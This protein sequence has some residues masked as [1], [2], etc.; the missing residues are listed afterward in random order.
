MTCLNALWIAIDIEINA[1]QTIFQADAS[2]ITVEALFLVY[3][4]SEL[5]VRFCAQR[6]LKACMKDRWFLFDMV[7]VMLLLLETWL[8]PAIVLL[9][10]GNGSD[11]GLATATTMLRILRLL[12][13]LRTARIARIV[14][15][16]PELL[17]LIKGLLVASKSVFFA[18]VLFLLVTY[19]FSIALL[20]LSEETELQEFFPSM[21]T[22]M[23]RLVVSA[24]MPDQEAFFYSVAVESWVMGTLVMVF[25]L[26]G[27]LILLNML[28]GILVE[29]VQTVAAMEHEQI[30]VDFAEH[31]LHELLQDEAGRIGDNIISEGEYSRLMAR[32]ET[33]AA[34]SRLGVDILSAREYGKLLF[35]EGLTVTFPQF[36]ES[37]L[38]LRG[39]NHS[40]VKDIVNLRKFT[41]AEFAE[42][43]S[44]LHE[45]RM[46]LEPSP[47]RQARPRSPGDRPP[48]WDDSGHFMA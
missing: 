35:E 10:H 39:S 15:Y 19:V 25:I 31:V 37:I 44:S 21:S 12:R 40:T 20:S 11:S 13:I 47:A 23:L 8:I 42:L 41:A 34:L 6:H 28:V 30:H 4:T 46:V 2:L 7:L 45:I 32:P 24:A 5:I 29:A 33:S 36:M 3:F 9:F 1:A 16:M 43:R 27:S 38:T 22:A 26:L 17:I 14:R 48:R 18:L